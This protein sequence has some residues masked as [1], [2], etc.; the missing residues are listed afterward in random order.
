LSAKTNGLAP[1]PI[2][3][4]RAATHSAYVTRFTP[5]ELQ[6]IAEIEDELRELTPVDSPAIEPVI[7]LAAGQIW[8]RDR[9]F[10]DL[11]EHGVTRGRADRGRVAPA[12]LALDALERQLAE[13]LKMLCV[14]PKGAATL[15]TRWRRPEAR[16]ASTST[17]ERRRARQLERLLDK[18]RARG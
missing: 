2:G 4:R 7:A 16:I 5:G 18:A 9:L 14:S 3:N 8:R 1:A 17:A 11:T 15:A 10:R 12:A 13:S 6:E